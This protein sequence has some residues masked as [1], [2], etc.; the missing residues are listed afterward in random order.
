M[1]PATSAKTLGMAGLLAFLFTGCGASV[2]VELANARDAVNRI[3]SGPTAT[4]NPA[5]LHTAKQTLAAAEHSY[6]VEGATQDTKDLAYT[7]ERRAE[8]AEVNGRELAWKR[9]AE[10]IE[11]QVQEA[12]AARLAQTAQQLA[13]TQEQLAKQGQELQD[14]RERRAEA[15]KRAAEAAANLAKFATVKQETRGMVITLSGNVMFESNKSTLFPGARE[16]LND[17]AEALTQ[18]D[19]ESQIV[20]EG[21]ADSRGDDQY[22]MELSQERAESVREYLVSQGIDANRIRAK[23]YGETRPIADNSSPEGRANNRR[24]EIVVQ[25]GPASTRA[26]SATDASQ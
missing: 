4:L 22:N 10:L 17:V 18:Q 14:E 15:E 25:Q 9:Q 5:G 8:V 19:P 21:H 12:E 3:E 6:E 1:N 20:V 16:K 24:V 11:K 23:G 13:A 7:A 2:P 26:A